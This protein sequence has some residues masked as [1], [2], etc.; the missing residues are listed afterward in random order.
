MKQPPLWERGKHTQLTYEI[1]REWETLHLTHGHRLRLMILYGWTNNQRDVLCRSSYLSDCV[2]CHHLGPTYSWPW[3]SK[4]VNKHNTKNLYL[5]RGLH[6]LNVDYHD[7]CVLD[8]GSIYTTNIKCWF[9][10]SGLF[11]Q[12]M[13]QILRLLFWR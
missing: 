8:G 11:A 12:I 2:T 3:Q 4:D 5:P 6:Q 10:W 1:W 13:N 7:Y 9:S